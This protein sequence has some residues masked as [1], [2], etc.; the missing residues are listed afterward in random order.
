MMGKNLSK[1]KAILLSQTITPNIGDIMIYWDKSG[2][3][4]SYQK[5]GHIAIYQGGGKWVSD[6]VHSS[7]VYKSKTG[8]C[9]DLIYLKS[10][11]FPIKIKD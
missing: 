1:S 11:N 5:Y 3:S 4:G 8:D 7:F 6:F 2:T 9:W 10:P